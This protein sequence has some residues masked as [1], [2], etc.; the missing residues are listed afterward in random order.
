MQTIPGLGHIEFCSGFKRAPLKWPVD[1][2]LGLV[3]RK[4]GYSKISL[5][6]DYS[7]F[8]LLFVFVYQNH[9]LHKQPL[10]K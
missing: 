7:L 4:S 8:M 2:S 5:E 10:S 9:V 6:K 3:G 1:R